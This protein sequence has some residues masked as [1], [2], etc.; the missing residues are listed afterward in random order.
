MGRPDSLAR[1]SYRPVRRARLK[2]DIVHPLH[3]YLSEQ[4]ALAHQ[5]DLLRAAAT[6]NSTRAAQPNKPARLPGCRRRIG[7][8]L[9]EI[10]LRL[11]TDP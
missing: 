1:R 8:K 11:A 3:P 5:R 9:V 2:A 10:G 7:W 6:Y 4:L